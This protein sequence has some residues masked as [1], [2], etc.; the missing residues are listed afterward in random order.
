MVRHLQL[1]GL[2]E[3]LTAALP[4]ARHLTDS[5]RAELVKDLPVVIQDC[6]DLRTSAPLE[7]YLTQWRQ[8]AAIL[9]DRE[10]ADRLTSPIKK[11]LG[12]R[13]APP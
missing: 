4:W 13:V 11:P 12:R 10:L 9:A 5:E 2:A 6:E 1:S 3:T 8:T 7:V